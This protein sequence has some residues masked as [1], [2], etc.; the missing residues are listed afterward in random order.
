MQQAVMEEGQTSNFTS[1]GLT[2]YEP[3]AGSS[4]AVPP[5]ACSYDDLFPAL[6][7]SAPTHV[8]HQQH[9]AKMRIG[10]SVVTQVFRVPYEE[11]K[12]DHSDKFGE[13]DSSCLSI[14]NGTG[15]HIEMSSSKDGS[16]TFLVTGKQSD[17]LE[18]RR[19]ILTQFQTQASKQ[20]SIPKE[21]HRWILGKKGEK[22]KEL[23]KSTATKINIPPVNETSDNI[24]ITGTREG[25]EKAEHEISVCSD[26][27]SKNTFERIS[28]PKIYHPFICGAMNENLNKMIQETGARINVPPPSFGKDEIVI[29]GEKEGVM[30]AKAKVEQIYKEMEKKCTTVCVEVPKSQ[31]K[32]VI[33]QKGSTIAEILAQTGVSVE[34]PASDTTGTITLRG[35]HDR[36]GLALNKVYEKANSVVATNIDAPAWIHKYIIGK[37]GVN[38]KKITQDTQVHVEFTENRVKIEGPPESVEQTKGE[39]EK[40][41]K[42]LISTFTF[43]EMPVDP[44]FYKHIIG[45]KGGNVNRLKDETSVMINIDDTNRI[46]IEG[47][48]EGVARAQRELQEMVEKLENEKEMDAIIDQ[49]HYRAIIGSKGDNIKEIRERFNQ[50][51][52]LFPGPEDKRNIVKI[53]GPKEDVDECY[54][55]LITYVKQLDESSFYVEVPIHKQFHKNIIG[56]GGANIRK[57]R[58][59]T[60][61]K[62]D[63]P[64]EGDKNDVIKITGKKENVMDARERIKS[65]QNELADVVTIDITIPPRYYNSLIGA[66]GR[67]IQSIMVE[68]GGVQIKFPPTES[69]SDKVTIRGPKDDA[70]RAKQQLLELTSERELCS[71]TEI[72]RAKP[73][74]HKFVIGKSGANIRKIRDSTGARIAFPKDED[75]D[76]EVITI[77]GTKEA[78][79][80][81]KTE[82]EAT[83]KGIVSNFL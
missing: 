13:S 74:H 48:K 43:V 17:V 19:K 24:T 66:G 18:A 64:A 61:T 80:R 8:A 29:A 23:E 52:V 22:L 56:K 77:F 69:K 78:V 82:L 3:A 45:K 42:N 7:E 6:P 37:K 70:E 58:D 11:R 71:F 53:R 55:Y 72:V 1:P 4:G 47:E 2:A 28:I 59:E 67:L 36:L 40:V 35:P 14:M 15:A 75:D 26:E 57:I 62:I 76:K 44:K 12:F 31:H 39:L 68:C 81:A 16:L 34:M 10:S 63:L 25:I 27:R 9:N 79:E 83:I 46:R 60:Q 54:K 49:K 30:T 38:I 5:A 73:E 20:I 51:Q 50:V 65:I 41:V 32:Y 21:H 33:G